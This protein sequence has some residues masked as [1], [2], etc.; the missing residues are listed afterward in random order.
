MSMFHHMWTFPKNADIQLL[1]CTLKV[2]FCFTKLCSLYRRKVYMDWIYKH[3]RWNIRRIF[4]QKILQLLFY[5]N[6]WNSW[7]EMYL[8]ETTFILWPRILFLWLW[9]LYCG[10]GLFFVIFVLFR[11]HELFFLWT[12]FIVFSTK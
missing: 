11:G 6:I 8:V 12:T 3:W 7:N 10:H 5:M 1:Q 9:L 2:L 4:R